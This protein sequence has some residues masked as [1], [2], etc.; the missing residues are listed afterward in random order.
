MKKKHTIL[1]DLYAPQEPND[2]TFEEIM[3][4]LLENFKPK[5]LIIEESQWFYHTKQEES[6]SVLDFFIQFK[7]LLL[8]ELSIFLDR[9][10]QDK[11]VCG[12]DNVNIQK[13]LLSEDVT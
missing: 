13:R 10:L 12:L 1:K 8:C 4:L 2:R 5:Y 11:F 7:Q 6:E 9:V 3:Q